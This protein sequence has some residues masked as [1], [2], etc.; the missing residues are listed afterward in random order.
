MLEKADGS[1]EGEA[2]D[3]EIVNITNEFD[4]P[5][6]NVNVSLEPNVEDPINMSLE[7]NNDNN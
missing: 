1:L 4:R 6:L 5:T 3:N 7:V 2:G